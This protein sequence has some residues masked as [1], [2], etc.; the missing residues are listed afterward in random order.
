[1][2]VS[3]AAL[4]VSMRGDDVAGILRRGRRV[5]GWTR[6]E[7]RRGEGSRSRS[8]RNA[9]DGDGDGAG[10]VLIIVLLACL[11]CLSW[12]LTAV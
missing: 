4:L 6:R 10:V 9:S 12:S 5:M 3:I 2:W 1:M 7:K 8:R 11:L